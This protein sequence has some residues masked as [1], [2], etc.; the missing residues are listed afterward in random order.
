MLAEMSAPRR[1]KRNAELMMMSTPTTQATHCGSA[2]KTQIAYTTIAVSTT[3][4]NRAI[5]L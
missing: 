4:L 5:P 2:A 1:P 3:K